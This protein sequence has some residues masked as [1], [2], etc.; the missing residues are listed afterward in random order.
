M[1]ELSTRPTT[2]DFDLIPLPNPGAFFGVPQTLE[3]YLR[4]SSRL[5]RRYT[6]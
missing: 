2:A 5:A 4:R 6:P 3:I 1:I